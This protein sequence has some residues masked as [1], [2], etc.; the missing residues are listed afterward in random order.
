[1]LIHSV[2]QISGRDYDVR[3]IAK[4]Y[5]YTI[6][7]AEY[8][9]IMFVFVIGPKIRFSQHVLIFSLNLMCPAILFSLNISI[10]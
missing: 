9:Q 1:M 4:V 6:Q 5:S 10:L 2:F 8:M 7:S 3:G